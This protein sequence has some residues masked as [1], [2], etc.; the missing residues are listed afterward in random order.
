[1]ELEESDIG[2]LF[3][4]DMRR[5]RNA[6][7][8]HSIVD[9]N[10]RACVSVSYAVE[11]E[12]SEIFA[13]HKVRVITQASLKEISLVRRGVVGQ[14]FAFITDNVCNPSIDDLDRST[15]FKLCRA[16]HNVRKA[17]RAIQDDA[18]QL[19]D[20]VNR[21]SAQYGFPPI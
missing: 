7:A 11:Q 3:R 16:D 12:R 5:A 20:R 6:N 13:G 17:T 4:L 8:I 9:G 14:A 10:N 1:L 19:T 21:L 2:L 15:M 18:A